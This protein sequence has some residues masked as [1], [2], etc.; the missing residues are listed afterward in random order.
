M[1]RP[2]RFKQF[3][4]KQAINAQKVGTDSMLLGAWV[5]GNFERILDIGTGTG[6]LALMMAQK[7]P[8]ADI[9]AIEPD[10]A[11]LNEAKDNFN[12]ST[13][14]DRMLAI[15]A[16][17]QTFGSMEKFDLIIS[18][19]P[20]FENAYLSDD[21]ERNRA[22]HTDQLP[23][24]ELYE[25]AAELLADNGE[26]YVVVPYDEESNHLSRAGHEDLYVKKLLRTRRPDGK[27]K[28]SLICFS[29]EEN[30]TISPETLLVK[31]ADNKY[32]TA[33]IELTKDFYAK[34]LSAE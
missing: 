15:H 21:L 4:V 26:F 30:D 25:Y 29:F 31:S 8:T 6:I 34:D 16:P 20:Y 23:V 13:Y 1:S 2:F 17:L 10:L 24:Y 12:A 27:Y 22:R 11:S 32:S 14:S 3:T 5:T 28:R 18:N 7:N 33:Y 9:T 19:P